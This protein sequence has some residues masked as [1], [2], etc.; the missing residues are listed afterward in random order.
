M[1]KHFDSID[2]L[3]KLP[4]IVPTEMFMFNIEKFL[5]DQKETAEVTEIPYHCAYLQAIS[6][7]TDDEYDEFLS[8]YM[9]SL[10]QSR[11]FQRTPSGIEDPQS[12][13]GIQLI[14]QNKYFLTNCASLDEG[15][16]VQ[17]GIIGNPKYQNKGIRTGV[18]PL[19]SFVVIEDL[20]GFGAEEYVSED[21]VNAFVSYVEE[22]AYLDSLLE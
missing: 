7:K 1:G 6:G 15:V 3:L 12:Y 11:F 8:E 17:A 4:L 14:K 20:M 16:M 18:K 22:A 21:L 5:K 9:Q 10:D 19:F 2:E 13:V